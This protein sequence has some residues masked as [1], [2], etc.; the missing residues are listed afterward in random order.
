MFSGGIGWFRRSS[1]KKGLRRL[2][3][4]PCQS[5]LSETLFYQP[6]PRL[7]SG[8]SLDLTIEQKRFKRSP[9]HLPVL[10]FSVPVDSESTF[11]VVVQGQREFEGRP[12]SGTPN[13]DVIILQIKRDRI[14]K[15]NRPGTRLPKNRAH[16]LV[17]VK[18]QPDG[19]VTGQEP[20][21]LFR[22]LLDMSLKNLKLEV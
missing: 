22:A 7:A 18:G 8:L 2:P 14:S 4:S 9:Y 11:P 20:H 15:A 19:I 10:E 21:S 12:V 17:L 6:S 3:P 1:E 16:S 5:D 13:Q